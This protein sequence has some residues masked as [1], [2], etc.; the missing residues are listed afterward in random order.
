MARYKAR[1]SPVTSPAGCKL[2]YMQ[3]VGE[4]TRVVIA[5]CLQFQVIMGAIASNF[6]CDCTGIFACVCSYFC[7]RL[8]GIF[9]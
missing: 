5:D 4:F 2:T 7:L 1:R 6:A 3:F 9:N 8:D